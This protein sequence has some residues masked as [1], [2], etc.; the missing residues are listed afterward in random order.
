MISAKTIKKTALAP[1]ILITHGG[2]FLAGHLAETLLEKNCRVVVLSNLTEHTDI[3]LRALVRSPKFA[4]FDC[5][6]NQEVPDTVESV[7]YIFHLANYDACVGATTAPGLDS[8]LSAGVGTKNLLDLAR[9]AQAKF[10]LIYPLMSQNR[11]TGVNTLSAGEAQ[12]YA[13]SLVTE[14][15]NRWG[16]D[17]RL[18]HLGQVYGPG[19]D[20]AQSG[21]LGSLLQ[22]VL[23][24]KPLQLVGDGVRKEFYV[25][26]SD[27]VTG[28]VKSLFSQSETQAFTLARAKAN[29]ALEV[30]YILKSLADGKAD[31]Q[32]VEAEG[33]VV[34]PTTESVSYPPNWLPKIE[35]K[36]GLG[37]T[38]R[39]FGYKPN[40]KSFKVGILID[41]KSS[42]KHTGGGVTLVEGPVITGLTSGS[43][44]PIN[45]VKH[46]LYQA[47][48]RLRQLRATAGRYV[49]AGTPVSSR[50][51]TVVLSVC[52]ILLVGAIVLGVPVL[53]SYK[54]A[55]A[56]LVDLE[57]YQA[58]I[59][60]LDAAKSQ[61]LSEDAYSH[62][63]KLE[64]SLQRAV[65]V[66]KLVGKEDMY[67]SALSFVGSAKNFSSALHSLALGA[68]PFAGLWEGMT[69]TGEGTF[70]AQ[71]F[72]ESAHHFVA[73]KEALGFAQAGL[74]G[75]TKE[76]LP[77]GVG[78]DFD[79]YA[80]LLTQV[81]E[82][83]D[84]MVQL[85][86]EFPEL[87]GLEEDRRYLLL[88]QNNNELRP[89]GGFVGSYAVVE[90]HAGKISKISIDDI[91][92]PDG[93]LALS[94]A[95]EGYKSPEALVQALG[96]EALYIRN[97]NWH[98]S[99][100]TSAKVI[101]DLFKLADGKDF[102]GVF[103]VDLYFARDVLS[104]VGPL[105]LAAYDE[106]IRVDN[107]YER[108]QF[109]SDFDF[110]AGQSSK[111][112]FI[113]VLG[114]K[115][116]ESVFALPQDKIP[117]LLSVVYSSLEQKHMLLNLSGTHFSR[118]LAERGWDGSLVTTPPETDY[119][120]VVN[121]NVGGTKSNYYVKNGM[122]YAVS[123]KT[124]DGVLRGE[125]EL[126]YEN[127]Q[128][129][130]DWPGGPYKN[131]V[132]VLV[133]EG[134][135]LTGA[136]VLGGQEA[137]A[138]QTPSDVM[139]AA[140]GLAIL[141]KVSI[142]KVGNYTS[143]EYLIV[144]HPQEKV[145][146]LINYDLPASLAAKKGGAKYTLVWQKQP[147]TQTDALRFMFTAPFGTKLS[148][149]VPSGVVTDNVYE[150]TSVLNSDLRVGIY[151]R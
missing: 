1:T 33:D 129:N 68:Q 79:R 143:F 133:A 128:K 29:T 69:P 14:Y 19:M 111:K 113:T 116:L 7:D 144:V 11:P 119:L 149:T 131:Y 46:R 25:Y 84:F 81:S 112:A 70:S 82:S 90:L 53:Q 135:K 15:R 101:T 89:T 34:E 12:K 107:M 123:S 78:A 60:R 8:L 102:D 20:L 22:S 50:V 75:V 10:M 71:D 24:A 104:V 72:K 108:A 134:S 35:L 56:A 37:K 117:A 132:R 5:D 95:N 125:L 127:T 59:T 145:T 138:Q 87:V 148:Q 16:L 137:T 126:T 147:G 40:T 3:K 80:K 18:V 39:S 100:P 62:L 58:A 21:E 120:Y 121:A 115:M 65:V 52:G 140:N 26:V 23:S 61:D 17:A 99:F 83:S 106:E 91:Y 109:H 74:S 54:H 41:H 63:A 6:V 66:F 45:G 114:G 85:A 43:A 96:E 13:T 150:Y 130:A 38:L 27:A 48:K 49:Q 30:A 32:F 57:N 110:K 51:K 122:T 103:A 73:A 44:P 64:T 36:E 94:K 55:Q 118:Y 151:Y 146:L 2:G 93:Q 92:N 31:L 86:L 139:G 67:R 47:E 141:D 98:P 76:K 77:A 136:Y 105:Y 97:A 124:S 9:S 42:R 28:L 4:L 142:T 88:F